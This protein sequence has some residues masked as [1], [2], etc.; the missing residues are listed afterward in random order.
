MIGIYHILYHLGLLTLLP[1]FFLK[2][3]RQQKYK[4]GFSQRVGVVPAELVNAVKGKEVIWLHAVSVGEV[5]AALP[6]INELVTRFPHYKYIVST[7]TNTGQNVARERLTNKNIPVFYFP[8][9]FFW[10]VDR[11]LNAISP[12]MVLIM[13]TE[14]WP[15]FLNA[16]CKRS[17]PIG[18]INGRLSNKSFRGYKKITFFLKPLL[19]EIKFVAAQS[20]SDKHKFIKL[21]VKEEN[22]FVTGNLKFDQMPNDTPFT[23]SQLSDFNLLKDKQLLIAGSTHRGEEEILI[24]V[25]KALMTKHPDLTLLL[26]P[27]HPERLPEVERLV[28]GA[29]LTPVRRSLLS[30]KRGINSNEVII[31]DTM[32]ELARIY[33]FATMVFIGKSL[34]PDGGG[35]NP[36][37]PAAFG[38]PIMVGPNVIN[39]KSIYRDLKEGEAIAEISDEKSLK[40]TTENFLSN[41]K[42][43]ETL[44]N[45]AR[46]AVERNRGTAERTLK[47]LQSHLE[48]A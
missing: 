44:G 45:N 24:R 43:R 2:M 1:L 41:P 17:I 27:R 29:R 33:Q 13:E 10:A 30:Q 6:L 40:E 46:R 18:I 4:A 22:I 3:F 15:A 34:I 35:Q 47:L 42:A 37:E 36:L 7:T 16:C 32:G 25:Y 19:K 20:A 39:F 23:Q 8:F 5:Q 38:K 26:A 12:K 48:I 28:A 14:I 31:L 21:G 11:V 9:D